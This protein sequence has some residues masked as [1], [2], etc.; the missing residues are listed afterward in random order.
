MRFYLTSKVLVAVLTVDEVLASTLST[1]K[2]HFL[3][4]QNIIAKS[5]YMVVEGKKG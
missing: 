3:N 4:H 5:K 1:N 2:E